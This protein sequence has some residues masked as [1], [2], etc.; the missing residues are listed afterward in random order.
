[1]NILP[2]SHSHIMGSVILEEIHCLAFIYCLCFSTEI[3]MCA[4][5]LLVDFFLD[6]LCLSV[7]EF[8]VFMGGLN[9]R[10]T[11]VSFSLVVLVFR[12]TI[13]PP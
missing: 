13:L 10:K 1:M 9:F 7:E 4:V 6:T 2:N 12:T 5:G 11:E 3:Y 8:T